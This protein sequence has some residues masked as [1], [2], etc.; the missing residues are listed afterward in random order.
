MLAR[1]ETCVPAELATETLG[2]LEKYVAANDNLKGA[3]SWASGGVVGPVGE[4]V[5]I[6]NRDYVVPRSVYERLLASAPKSTN[7]VTTADV[8]GI[9]YAD[10]DSPVVP[11]LTEADWQRHAEET[12]FAFRQAEQPPRSQYIGLQRSSHLEKT[13]QERLPQAVRTLS[14]LPGYIYLGTAYSKYEAGH[15]AASRVAADAAARLMAA[16][17]C[18]FAPI[19]HGHTITLAGDLPKDWAF[20]KKQCDPMIEAAAGMVVLTMHGWQESVGLQYEIG[21]FTR[22]GKPILH[23]SPADLMTLGR[24]A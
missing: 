20:W 11:E 5:P 21:E 14:R 7:V 22:W 2:P 24:V 3:K 10:D 19:P 16:G 4:V 23:A 12:S 18:I 9:N 6:I 13:P 8:V 1:R 15:D 17:L